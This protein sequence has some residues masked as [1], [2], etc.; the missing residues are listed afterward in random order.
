MGDRPV[1]VEGRIEDGDL[2]AN[3]L[4][5]IHEGAQDRAQL[6]GA[7]P[8][9]QAVVDRRHDGIVQDVGVEVN[10]EARELAA[11]EVVERL[12]GDFLC[13]ERLHRGEVVDLHSGIPDVPAAVV[14][15][16]L[17]VAVTEH[18][19][20]LFGDQRPST[21]DVGEHGRAVAGDDSEV[22]VGDGACRRC[23]GVVE[24]RVSVQEE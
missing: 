5:R 6:G 1:R 21:L 11:P 12:R 15:G 10:P 17:R 16:L 19:H 14:S 13:A 20:V 8:T 9:G 23:L 18:D 3:G 22:H 4:A 7:E 24:V 2:E